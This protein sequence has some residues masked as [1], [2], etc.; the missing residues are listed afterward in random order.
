MI[1]N[2]K[3]QCG[4]IHLI[5]LLLFANHNLSYAQLFSNHNYKFK[6]FTVKDGLCHDK[7]NRVVQD[8][9][10]FIWIAT[11][12]GLS[13]FDGHAFKNFNRTLS[14]TLSLPAVN[15]LDMAIDAN[16]NLW[17][18]YGHGFCKF[19][20]VTFKSQIYYY[21]GKTIEAQIIQYS[22]ADGC[23]YIASF[24]NGL[25]KLDT[26]TNSVLATSLSEKLKHNITSSY[27]DTKG[28]LWLTVERN[29]YYKYHG[30]TNTFDYIDY[31]EWPMFVVEDTDFKRYYTGSWLGDFMT[32]DG[33]K[34]P[35][36]KERHTLPKKFEGYEKVTITACCK[37]PKITGANILWV[38]SYHGIGLFDLEK[39]IF[40]KHFF[41]QPQNIDGLSNNW[42]TKIFVDRDGQIWISSWHG[43]INVNPV[44]QSF[45]KYYLPELDINLYNLISG[46]ADDPHDHKKVWMAVNGSGIAQYDRATSSIK[47]WYFKEF[48][49]PFDT[50]YNRRWC[51]NIKKDSNGVLWIGSYGG[52]A[53]IKNGKVSFIDTWYNGE[54]IYS[55]DVF[56]DRD[57]ML[58]TMGWKLQKFN[59]YSETYETYDLPDSLN[60]SVEYF[61]VADGEKSE[62]F[63]GTSKGLFLFNDATQSFR[64][65]ELDKKIIKNETQNIR[66]L[67]RINDK[68]FIGTYSGLFEYNVKSKHIRQI[69]SSFIEIKGLS[70][71]NFNNLWAY[72]TLGLYRINS[73][74]NKIDKFDQND[75]VYNLS[76]DP[77]TFFEYNNEMYIG[78]RSVFTKF[79][80]D[81]IYSNNSI[82]IPYITE[83]ACGK[84]SSLKSSSDLKNLVLQ[85]N[86]SDI[87]FQFTAIEFNY[88]S[89]LKFSYMLEG[90]DKTWSTFSTIRSKSYTG[91]PPGTYTFK[92]KARNSI[93]LESETIAKYEFKIKPAFW[94]TW[95]F[96]TLC[97]LS[98]IG[99]ILYISRQ[100][101]VQIRKRE[102][103]KTEANKL[104]AELDSKLLRSQM[105]PHFIFNSLNSIQKYIWEN[106]E[107]DAAEYL[108]KFAKLMRSI[109]ENSSKEFITLEEEF[110]TLKIYLELEH[111]RSNG[112]FD[113]FINIDHKLD[114]ANLLT[115]PM[116]I[117]PFIENAIWHG[118]NKKQDHGS[119]IISVYQNSEAL[120]FSVDDDGIGRNLSFNKSEINEKKSLGISITKQRIEKLFESTKTKGTIEIVDKMHNGVSAGTNVIISIPL[121]YVTHA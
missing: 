92:V 14:D 79:H 76:S 110:S 44:A 99:T 63:V 67:I 27:I 120:T 29:G 20:P 104:I 45:V 52:F 26:K 85:Y 107:E 48:L 1:R 90:Y 58:W 106:N 96:K 19:D 42:L 118:L 94:Q 46:I 98:F 41:Y 71:D 103:E 3:R 53:K 86:E 91:L 39:N 18:A 74:T 30:K 78:N 102:N 51:H 40:I 2:G 47:K 100:R 64:K 82:P 97:L 116:L 15:I 13:R 57:G 72:T 69:L 9:K 117:Q 111:K 61:T 34:L 84:Y 73:T 66:S 28:I 56:Q 24:E 95:W 5:F 10:G 81:N 114:Q 77:C 70:K 6:T 25:F 43:L 31:H 17:L 12:G 80:P 16:D 55:N 50:N 87:T 60:N 112:H 35:D 83:I 11:E 37:A 21:K 38:T 101:I 121:K 75:G 105:N 108:S 36:Y 119:L 89:K 49:V 109:L 7:V 8:S 32:F 4:I 113:Y 59:P 62:H 33:Y 115:P 68:L 65:V 54:S 23:I 88:P 22:P 93:D